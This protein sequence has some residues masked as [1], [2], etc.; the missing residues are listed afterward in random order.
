MLRKASR[1]FAARALTVITAAAFGTTL[2][3]VASPTNILIALAEKAAMLLPGLLIVR[4]AAGPTAGWLPVVA[5]GPFLG[6]GLSSLSLLGFWALGARGLWTLAAAPAVI[7][8]LVPLARRAR[9]RWSF[10]S[11]LPGDRT[12]LLAILLLVPVI[13]GAPF[14]HVGDVVPEGKAYRAYF[15]ADYVW[16]RAVVAEV[17]KGEMPPANPFYRDDALHYYWLPHLSSAVSYRNRHVDLDEVLLLHS[18]V[19]DAAFVTF[20]FGLARWFVPVPWAAALGVATAIT[21]TSYEGIYALVEYW[22][23]N[24]ALTLVR[25]LNIDAVTRWWFHAMP[26]DGLQRVLFYQPH[27]AI[28]YG[29]GF[30]GVLAVA[31]RRRRFDPMV[32]AVAGVLL[33]LSTLVSSFA[34]LMLTCVAALWEAG[35]VLRWREWWRAIAHATAAA[36]PLALAAALVTAL[37]YVDAG[38]SIITFG[39]N[40]LA[41]VSVW[42]SAALSFGPMLILAAIAAVACVRLRHDRALV[43]AALW[44][45]CVAFYFYVDIRDHQDVYVGWR[46]GHLWLIGSAG[47]SAI[48]FQW[49]SGL[50]AVRRRLVAVAVSI[51]LL[52]ALPTTLIDV[53]NTQDIHNFTQGSG[54]TWTLLLSPQEQEGLVWIKAHTPADAVFQL[55]ALKRGAQGWAYLPAFA[56]RR[57]GVGL[58]ISMVPLKKYQDGSRWATWLF[59]TTSAESAHSLA[60]HN[61]IQYLYLGKAEREQHPTAQPRFDAAPEYFE[62]VFR[63]SEATIYRV[64]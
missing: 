57:M 30:M 50:P 36:L 33:G 6:F 60:A 64:K 10:P 45:T 24:L 7:L 1:P 41:F 46:V 4:A 19:I 40:P 38:G 26:I 44:L 3:L 12:A 14:A 16:R 9:D 23:F 43:F 34:G 53:Y 42:F 22:R 8:L 28:G 48:A 59:E 35:S 27:H 62:E 31:A 2:S 5:F 47:L 39:P 11:V 55:D 25:D 58:P 13:V 56:E 32:F 63:N 21:T 29:L 52:A 61:G 15:T 17:A 54:F 20:L 37:Q 49:L 51:I 18:V